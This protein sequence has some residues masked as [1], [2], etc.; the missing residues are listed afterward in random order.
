MSDD[1]TT[2]QDEC[3]ET[4]ADEV[5]TY[6]SASPTPVYD[7]LPDY[8]QG[9]IRQITVQIAV[10][11]LAERV[12]AVNDRLRDSYDSAILRMRDIARGVASLGKVGVSAK[13]DQIQILSNARVFRRGESP[14]G[15]S[16]TMGGW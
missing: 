9:I 11:R 16:G 5:D 14:L 12:G 2:I 13:P 10:Y 8:G 6:L 3:I 4:A 7:A 15:E 1:D